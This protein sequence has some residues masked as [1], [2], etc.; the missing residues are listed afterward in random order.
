[1]ME[2][3]FYMRLRKAP[4]TEFRRVATSLDDFSSLGSSL[5]F[6]LDNIPMMGLEIEENDLISFMNPMCPHCGSRN[7]VKN[8]T[9]IRK[10]ENGTVFRVQR[11]ISNDCRFSFVARPP[12]FGYG[13]H[14]PDNLREKGIRSRI[15]KSLRKA[16]NLFRILRN[17]MISHEPIR[18]CVPSPSDW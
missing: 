4:F 16:A 12:N 5:I 17:L 3:F 7:V 2:S 1:M 15:K 10:L 14:F 6:M 8:G 11:Y 18:R 13:K 9:C